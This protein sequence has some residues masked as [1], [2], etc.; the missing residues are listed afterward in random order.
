MPRIRAAA[1]SSRERMQGRSPSDRSARSLTAPFSPREAHSST[2]RAPPSARRA[3]V[4]PH[5]MDSSS[6]WA[7]TARMVRPAKSGASGLEDALI[8]GDVLTYHSIDTEPRHR[9][10]AD[11]PAIKTERT[12]QVFHHLAK[13]AEDEARHPVVDHLAHSAEIER[14]DW[15]AAG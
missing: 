6:G 14:D 8:D 10:F 4:P 3:S 12:R 5:A 13:I 7:K 15:R 11:A 1:C 9:A 2:T